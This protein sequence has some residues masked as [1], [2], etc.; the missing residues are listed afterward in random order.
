M[1]RIYMSHSKA[2]TWPCWLGF[3]CVW[4]GCDFTSKLA[5]S[6]KFL[7]NAFQRWNLPVDL[8]LDTTIITLFEDWL[9]RIWEAGFYRLGMYYTRLCAVGKIVH[10]S[11][12]SELMNQRW[13]IAGTPTRLHLPTIERYTN[14]RVTI[15]AQKSLLTVQPMCQIVLCVLSVLIDWCCFY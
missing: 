7:E 10:Q 2:S 11:N 6:P 15:Q 1:S 13:N 4:L 5:I 3:T 8:H 12:W 9:N 14:T